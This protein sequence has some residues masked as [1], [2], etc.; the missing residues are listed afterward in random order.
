M[1]TVYRIMNTACEVIAEHVR[2]DLPTGKR[3][4]WQLPGGD[5]RDGLGG[6]GTADLPLYNSQLIPY[7]DAGDTVVICEGERATETVCGFGVPAL[8]TITGASGTPGEDALSVLLPFDVVTWEDHDEPG[9]QHMQRVAASLVRLG[10]RARRLVWGREKGDDA[11]D[12]A[13]RGGTRI[14]LDLLIHGADPW[15]LEQQA[16]PKLARPSYDRPRATG[17]SDGPRQADGR[18]AGPARPAEAHDGPLAVL[19]LPVP[20]RRPRRRRS[21][22]I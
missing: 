4:F 6:L 11:A 7:W 8:G 21:R 19:E 5:P 9:H 3:M 10:G 20:R 18:G 14:T 22:S 12:F 16:A 1:R 15:V 17:G 13:G 2:V